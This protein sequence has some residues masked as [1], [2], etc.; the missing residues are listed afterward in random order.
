MRDGYG[1][2]LPSQW[3]ALMRLTLRAIDSVATDDEARPSWT[4]G[5]GTALALEIGHRFSYD[6]DAFLDSARLIQSLVPVTNAVT[7]TICW[8]DETK[9]PDYQ[10]PRHYLKLVVKNVGEI[11]FLGASPLLAQSTSPFDF[12][13]RTILRERPAEIIAKKIFHRGS[14]FKAR[15][16]FDLAG[17]YIALRDELLQASSSPFLTPEIYSRVRFRIEARIGAFEEEVAEEVNPT[18]FGRSYIDGACELALDALH[19]MESDASKL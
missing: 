14:T 12:E 2:W 3:H 1:R 16:I 6:I 5:G 11:D 9:R 15:D 19:A 13:G 7:R 18:D 8:N 17:T 10:Y 4:F